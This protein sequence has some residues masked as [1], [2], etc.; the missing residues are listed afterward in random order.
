MQEFD[1]EIKYRKG[2][3][4]QITDHLSRLKSSGNVER[5]N[6]EFKEV[7]LDEQVFQVEQEPKVLLQNMVASILTSWFANCANHSVSEALP[8]DMSIQQKK[9]FLHDVKD[10]FWDDQYL[11]KLCLDQI[12]RICISEEE[13]EDILKSCHDPAYGGHS[14]GKKTT[15]N[16]LWTC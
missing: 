15:F 8:V 11:F 14:N 6:M 16:Y 4:N 1:I 12:M 3:E 10:Y 9:S 13:Q 5:Q 7:F 2:T